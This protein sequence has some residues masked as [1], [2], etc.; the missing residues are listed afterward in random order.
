ME[1][2]FLLAGI[3]TGIPAGYLISVL[4][5][6]PKVSKEQQV[7]DGVVYLTE[8]HDDQVLASECT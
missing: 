7:K 1:F 8:E 3:V 4:K 2:L 5:Q 6:L